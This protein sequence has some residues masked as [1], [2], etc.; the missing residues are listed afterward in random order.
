MRPRIRLSALCTLL[1]LFAAPADAQP[2]TATAQQAVADAQAAAGGGASAPCSYV[3]GWHPPAGTAYSPSYQSDLKYL[4]FETNLI[5]P[6]GNCNKSIEQLVDTHEVGGVNIVLIEDGE[7]TQHHFYGDRDRK[8]FEPTLADTRYQAASMSKFVTALGIV[9][10]AR[11]GHVD[12]SESVASVARDH[13]DSL[14]ADWIDRYFTGST[15]GWAEKITLKRLLSHTAGLGAHSVGTAAPGS[16]PTLRDILLDR[17]PWDGDPVEPIY[18]PRRTRDYSGGGYVV[19]E[20]VLELQISGS[21]KEFLQEEILDPAGMTNSSFDKA[22]SSMDD[23]ARGCSRWDC[24]YDVLQTNAKAAGGLLTTAGDY[25]RLVQT[26]MNNGVDVEGNVVIPSENIETILT[27]AM[28][29]DSTKEPCSRSEAG[30][31]KIV[32]QEFCVLGSCFDLAYE[33]V[34]LQRIYRRPLFDIDS[35]STYSGLGVKMSTE[36]HRDGFSRF[37]EHGGAHDGFRSNFKIDRQTDRGI[38]VMIN[39]NREWTDDD[40]F[41][42]GADAFIDEI[43]AA[44]DMVYID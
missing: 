10:A 9:E 27:P 30:D 33:E 5:G 39:G 34:C 28:H 21:F 32:L 3:E 13:P 25:A 16:V 42:R 20:H 12:L 15:A 24:F 1:A 23:L 37:V 41:E 43:M 35:G 19:A 17:D 22:Q 6:R 7:I 4:D 2:P 40:G 38:V 44:W 29:E 11:Q 14:L 31:T 36:L 18:A 26:F 8:A